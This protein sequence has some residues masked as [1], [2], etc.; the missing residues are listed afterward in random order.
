MNS[1]SLPYAWRT[2]MHCSTECY[3]YFGNSQ[4]FGAG[5]TFSKSEAER[6]VQQ[7]TLT[8]MTLLHYYMLH[9]NTGH[10]DL[11]YKQPQY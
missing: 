2:E 6:I 10:V 5:S 1:A 3:A 8:L 9:I 7:V 4:D 11:S